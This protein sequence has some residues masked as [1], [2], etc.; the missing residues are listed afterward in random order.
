MEVSVAVEFI[1]DDEFDDEFE[2]SSSSDED[3]T[4][5]LMKENRHCI[6]NYFESIIP[7]YTDHEFK[8]HFRIDRILFEDL[9]NQLQNSPIYTKLRGHNLVSPA[10]HLAIFLWF[11]GHEACSYRDLAD[12]FNL[13][14]WT[15]HYII[16]RVTMFLSSKAKSI[17]KWP[18]IHKMKNTSDYY[19]REK[20]FPGIIGKSQFLYFGLF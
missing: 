20:K 18:S 14:L 15:I 19:L 13:S 17:I 3:L 7:T 1:I 11:A 2:N 10:K 6:V 8:T 5:S 9:C 12:R 16:Y 4:F